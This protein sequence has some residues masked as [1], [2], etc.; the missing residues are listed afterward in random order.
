[1]T[2][3]EIE[4]NSKTKT[5]SATIKLNYDKIRDLSHGMYYL[6]KDEKNND[7]VSYQ[8]T[9]KEI[10]LLFDLVKHGR[11]DKCSVEMLEKLQNAIETARE[12]Q[13]ERTRKAD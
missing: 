5:F 11:L 13:N 10:A 12:K 1:M 3:I 9:H 4:H 2:I 8:E 6:C 7:N